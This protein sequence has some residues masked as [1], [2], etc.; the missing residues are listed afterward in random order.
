MFPRKYPFRFSVVFFILISCLLYFSVKLVLIQV[1]HSSFLSDLAKKQHNHLIKLEPTRGTIFDRRKRPL[2]INLPVYSLFANPKIIKKQ[3][4]K[5]ATDFL[6]HTMGLDP[7]LVERQLN[8][9][10]YFLKGASCIYLQLQA[11][12]VNGENEL[13]KF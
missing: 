4:K 5:K 12:T 8:K 6:I 7:Q 2:A 11:M 1:F 3:D 13:W 9:N 10:K